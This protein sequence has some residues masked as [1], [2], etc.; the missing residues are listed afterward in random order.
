MTENETMLL[1]LIRE[2]KNPEKALVAAIVIITD[3]LKQT[4]SDAPLSAEMGQYTIDQ[5][6]HLC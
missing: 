4:E 5:R 2:H 1:N 3:Y 6:L